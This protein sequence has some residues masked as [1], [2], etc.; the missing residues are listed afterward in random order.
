M[1]HELDIAD[2][3]MLYAILAMARSWDR[4]KQLF[5]S[6]EDQ[7]AKALLEKLELEGHVSVI[8][9]P[10]IV[11]ETTIYELL[12]VMGKS[13]KGQANHD[14]AKK[15]LER[16]AGVG[17]TYDGEKWF[18]SFRMM[19][20]SVNRETKAVRVALNP[21]SAASVMSNSGGY[22]MVHLQE[23]G[24][25]S[26]DDAKA[27]HSVL[28][29]LVRPGSSRVVMA[30]T[31]SSSVWADYDDEVS[32]KAIELRRKRLKEAAKDISDLSGW[33]VQVKG[34]GRKTAFFVSRAK[35]YVKGLKVE[36]ED[37]D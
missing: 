36:V 37:F 12:N 11:V 30:D 22:V 19:S 16:L 24:A 4:G 1:F 28:A 17:F 31:L 35:H 2:Q 20:F 27:L 26:K 7:D 21:V 25:L 23:R 10:S 32:D 13:P 8:T 18:G 15:S 33:K 6:T 14:W 5:D 9:K 29:G 34:K 3:S